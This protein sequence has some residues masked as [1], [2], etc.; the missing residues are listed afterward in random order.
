M[1]NKRL[2]WYLETNHLISSTQT[3]YRKHRSTEDQL[4]LLA[5]EVENGFQEKKK[6]LAVFFD[7]TQAFDR[8]WKEGLLFKLLQK[9]IG[10]RLF[11]WIKNLLIHRT[12][13][14]IV[15]GEASHR[16]QLR[17]GVPQGG[18]ISP[19][20]FLVFID[21]ITSCVPQH[22]SNTLHADD[23]AVWSTTTY[24]T[25]AVKRIQ[26]TVDNVN[27]WNIDWGQE[28]SKTKTC[29][30]LFSLSPKREEV[31]ITFG[32]EIIPLED[33]PTFIG[34]KHDTR[35]TWRPHIETISSRAVRKLALMKKL[36]GTN[37]GANPHVLRQVYVGSVRP[38]VEYASASWATAAKSNKTQLDRVQNMGLRM[39]LGAVK[40]TPIEEME[41]TADLQPLEERRNFKILTQCEKIR[42]LSDH[43]LHGRLLDGTRNRLKR[44]SQLHLATE[45]RKPLE[46]II[47]PYDAHYEAETLD[48]EPWSLEE[49]HL[50]IKQTIPGIRKKGDEPSEVQRVLTL[51]LIDR[52]YPRDKWIHV[53]TDGS[54]E[55]AIKNGG[56]GAYIRYPD[57]PSTSISKPSGKLCSNFKAEV[58]A[59]TLAAEHLISSVSCTRNVVIL[60]DSL[61]TI[62]AL[63]SKNQ[64]SCTIKLKNCLRQLAELGNLVIQWIPAHCGIPGN[65]KADLLAKHAGQQQQES[66]GSSYREAKTLL[67]QANKISWQKRRGDQYRNALLHLDRK[68]ATTIF[69]LVRTGHCRLKAHLKRIGIVDSPRCPCLQADQTP[70]HI[71]QDC[72]LWRAQRAHFWP[73][74]V[75]LNT[76]LWGTTEDLLRTANYMDS[77]GLIV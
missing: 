55:N 28:A 53:Y 1:V 22:V 35:L 29:A 71:L 61:S 77:I 9:G 46:D 62:Q 32:R 54:A 23:F 47:P 51:E 25:T 6:T 5:Q 76:Q 63:E 70:E 36:S 2:L 17:E 11:S 58:S 10:G 34:V 7:L 8:V 4:S 57:D 43:P 15:D 13:R 24:T 59:I 49:L 45:L 65:E 30:T 72:P 74:G 14:V 27:Q 33:T 64:D 42:R 56:S 41:K 69:R 44:Q 21:D 31:R 73:D 38:V 48:P 12:A 60:T 18:V 16:V 37:W 3:G 50:K 26:A 67:K 19:V 40:T 20:L 52:E 39:I 75:T 66:S 68:E